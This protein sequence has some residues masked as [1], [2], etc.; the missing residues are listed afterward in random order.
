MTRDPISE[1]DKA[2]PL[3]M[4]G[5]SC[6]ACRNKKTEAQKQGFIERQ[7]QVE[8]ANRR[9]QPHIGPPLEHHGRRQCPPT[10]ENTEN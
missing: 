2:S 5:V 6:P 4:P 3:Y 10:A 9:R 8:Y 7:R 1:A